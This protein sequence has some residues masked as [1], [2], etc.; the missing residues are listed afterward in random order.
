MSSLRKRP[1]FRQQVDP[2]SRLAIELLHRVY[3]KRLRSIERGRVLRPWT[4][5][6]VRVQT[7]VQEITGDG[8]FEGVVTVAAIFPNAEPFV[9]A[10]EDFTNAERL[11]LPHLR[12]L[13][14]GRLVEVR[15]Q[16][17]TE[18]M[19]WDGELT[20]EAHTWRLHEGPQ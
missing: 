16:C 14:S 9:L 10:L 19:L 6:M 4:P 3:G 8:C 20:A 7:Q 17:P 1:R 12:D 18:V 11:V 2:S 13:P 15:E 5:P